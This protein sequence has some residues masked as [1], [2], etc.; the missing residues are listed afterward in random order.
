[1]VEAS[2]WDST[3]SHCDQLSFLMCK[4]E[5]KKHNSNTTSGMMNFFEFVDVS[6][7]QLIKNNEFEN[8]RRLRHLEQLGK[9]EEDVSADGT[10][11]ISETHSLSLIAKFWKFT[12]FY[13]VRSLSEL[14][15]YKNMSNPNNRPKR[16][17]M[18]EKCKQKCSFFCVKCSDISQN[19]IFALCSSA[20]NKGNQCFYKHVVKG[21][22]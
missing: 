20:D 7:L 9:A 21:I 13:I 18:V 4:Y 16:E 6:A 2:F 5:F 19:K 12:D 17:C 8:K 15:Q 3:W 1:M 22:C 11:H 10:L 14:D